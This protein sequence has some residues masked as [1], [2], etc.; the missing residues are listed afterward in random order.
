MTRRSFCDLSITADR[1]RKIYERQK[2]LSF[3]STVIEDI[4]PRNVFCNSALDLK[5]TKIYG[6]DYDYT[7]A[8]YKTSLNKLIY[9]L[10]MGRLIKHFK[11]CILFSINL[12]RIPFSK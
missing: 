9:D 5:K 12:Y 3:Q 7:L 10:A 2:N 11:V 6:F 8:I 1:L 4:N